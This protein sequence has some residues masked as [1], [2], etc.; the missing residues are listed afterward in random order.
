[1]TTATLELYHALIEAGV[2][3]DK[4]EAAARAVITRQEAR[5]ILVTK[6]E[7]YKAMMIQS[8]VIISALGVLITLFN[9][10]G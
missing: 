3:T 4:A 2:P 7:M 8:G 1:M 10:I 5:D 6:D 9:S